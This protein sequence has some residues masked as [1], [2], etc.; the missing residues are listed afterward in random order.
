[1]SHQDEIVLNR[2]KPE[3]GSGQPS[4]GI[5]I[6][7]PA[8]YDNWFYKQINELAD[9]IHDGRYN[10]KSPSDIA[11]EILKKYERRENEINS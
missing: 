9:I 1:M 4:K 6:T 3:A 11:K 10:N 5:G 2:G 7:H 8:K